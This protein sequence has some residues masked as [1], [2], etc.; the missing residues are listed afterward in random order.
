MANPKSSP[1]KVVAVGPRCSIEVPSARAAALSIYLR[2]N[3]ITSDTPEPSSSGVENI[4]LHR[5]ADVKRVQA[6]LDAWTRSLAKD[7]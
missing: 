4:T 3:G 1:L 5:G 2:Q 7:A 6:L